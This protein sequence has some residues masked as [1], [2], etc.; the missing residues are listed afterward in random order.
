MNYLIKNLK[1]NFFLKNGIIY[2]MKIITKKFSLFLNFLRI[3]LITNSFFITIPKYVN[4]NNYYESSYDGSR[5]NYGQPQ[6]NNY[7]PRYSNNNQYHGN[8]DNY[9]QSQDNNYRPRY[10]NNNQ[11]HGNRDA[12]RHEFDGQ[13]QNNNYYNSY[14]DPSSNLSYYGGKR[15]FSET[16]QTFNDYKT[17]HHKEK[18]HPAY[19][20]WSLYQNQLNEFAH[21]LKQNQLQKFRKSFIYNL[22]F[23]IGLCLALNLGLYSFF[24]TLK[25][26]QLLPFFIISIFILIIATGFSFLFSIF[27][28]FVKSLSMEIIVKRILL[29]IFNICIF[30]GLYYVC[31]TQVEINMDSTI[32]LLIL[33]FLLGSII[34]TIIGY[35]FPQLYKIIFFSILIG[36]IL[37]FLSQKLFNKELF[38]FPKSNND[39]PQFLTEISGYL[40]P[41]LAIGTAINEYHNFQKKYL[42][43]NF[44]LKDEFINNVAQKLSIDIAWRLLQLIVE[45]FA[46]ILEQNRKNQKKK[47]YL[48]KDLKEESIED[49]K[50]ENNVNPI[51]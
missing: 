29:F 15:H 19:T 42:K 30:S 37:G 48:K 5:D 40:L 41:S 17:I 27:N 39:W 47:N 4:K 50:E 33:R 9:G 14:N 18:F 1:I 46:A 49:F 22:I 20:Y 8:R 35:I 24:K 16:T 10:S 43:E 21:L 6:D 44:F 25:S 7:Q 11:Y 3:N 28:F 2:I 36:S 51:L 26:E 12:R 38:K 13:Y 45:L 31:R 23:N 34:T 32:K